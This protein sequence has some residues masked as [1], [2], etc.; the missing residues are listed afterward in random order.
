MFRV[1]FQRNQLPF[2][3]AFRINGEG[4]EAIIDRKMEMELL[5]EMGELGIGPK[6]FFTFTNGLV[7]QYFHGSP[8]KYYGNCAY[9]GN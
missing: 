2:T 8:L 5:C 9:Y 3:V 4:T 1:D 6:V 7:Y